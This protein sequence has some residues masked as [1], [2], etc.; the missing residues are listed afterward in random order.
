MFSFLGDLLSLL[1]G[2]LLRFPRQIVN[3]LDQSVD[4]CIE[5]FR[6]W[7][8]GSHDSRQ[9]TMAATQSSVGP[10]E[11]WLTFVRSVLWPRR[12]ARVR[13]PTRRSIH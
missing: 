11:D 13:V 2:C 10:P 12:L 1:L 7:L 5:F 8:N 4:G 3:E 6:V 9:Q